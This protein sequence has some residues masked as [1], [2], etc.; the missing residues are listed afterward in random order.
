MRLHLKPHPGA[1]CAPTGSVFSSLLPGVGHAHRSTIG[2]GSNDTNLGGRV[3]A[4]SAQ[5]RE[6]RLGPILR[7][8]SEKTTRGLW[9]EEQAIR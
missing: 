3:V 1:P 4:G 9:I 5:R 6:T 8:A 2:P 7:H